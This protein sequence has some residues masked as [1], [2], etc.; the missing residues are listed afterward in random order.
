MKTRILF[1][2][3]MLGIVTGAISVYVYA[4]RLKPQPPLT[5]NYNPY[6]NGIYATGIVESLQPNGSN[7]NI[8]P[9]VSGKII[10]VFS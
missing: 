9:E 1:I 4:V 8:Y 5:V 2:I 6:I 3:A 10:K 7:I